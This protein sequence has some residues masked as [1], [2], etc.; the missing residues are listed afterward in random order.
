MDQLEE[1]AQLRQ[2]EY[3]SD[4]MV[5]S[6]EHLYINILSLEQSLAAAQRQLDA[7]DRSLA[8]MQLRYNQG[9][10]SELALSKQQVARSLAASNLATLNLTITNNKAQLQVMIGEDSTGEITLMDLPILSATQITDM[11]YDDDLEAAID[12]S[13]DLYLAG[14]DRDNA[15]KDWKD[16]ASGYYQR[17]AKRTYE[18]EKYLYQAKKQNFTLAFGIIYRAV[19][20]KQQHAEAAQLAL[21]YAELNYQAIL[22]KYQLGQLSNNDLYNATD[23]LQAA[24]DDFMTAQ[25]DL[26]SAYNDYC[27]ALDGYVD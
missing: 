9:Q 22:K 15:Y 2:Y 19:A 14:L 7:L 10:I 17:V 11:N 18:Y 20:D 24:Q 23:N 12:K 26:F 21:Q 8:E 6:A 1:G 13:T 3:A 16:A 5:C 27:W 4:E 25:R